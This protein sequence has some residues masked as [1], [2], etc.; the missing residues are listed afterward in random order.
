M[1]KNP[2]KKASSKGRERSVGSVIQYTAAVFAGLVIAFPV[3][4]LRGLS[5]GQA[6]YLN[7][8]YCSDGFFVAAMLITG[9]GIL[10]WISTTGFFDILS[11]AAHNMQV[12][13]SALW[14]P[15]E[16]KT[17]YDYKAMRDEKRGKPLY[18]LVI[19]GVGYLILAAICLGLY[20]N[21][22]G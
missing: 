20:Y 5:L 14:R 8:R 16:H 10:V 15:K 7:A 11:Y 3:A 2:P 12:L 22:P 9:V 1:K 21:L 13:L 19:V 17:Y 4:L 6:A 18:F